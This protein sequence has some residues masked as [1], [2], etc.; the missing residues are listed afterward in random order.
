MS[1]GLFWMCSF[2]VPFVTDTHS[3]SSLLYW[4]MD[5][6]YC[7]TNKQLTDVNHFLL[8]EAI[9]CIML[10]VLFQICVFDVTLLFWTCEE[11]VVAYVYPPGKL[12]LAL[13][14]INDLLMPKEV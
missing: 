1:H 14:L 13:I 11:T 9:F 3:R 7:K 5:A 4:E 8:L 6:V 12:N 2:S 10:S